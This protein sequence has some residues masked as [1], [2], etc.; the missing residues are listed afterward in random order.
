MPSF[1]GLTVEQ[2]IAQANDLGVELK[3]ASVESNR[4]E[5]GLVADTEPPTDTPIRP[6][7]RV[8]IFV[9]AAAS[10]ASG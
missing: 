10:A 5:V 3:E 9:S 4:W 6:G 2:A 7:A 8:T 1:V